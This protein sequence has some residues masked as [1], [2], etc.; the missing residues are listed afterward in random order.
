MDL[1]RRLEK[2][3]PVKTCVAQ[4]IFFLVGED[5]EGRTKSKFSSVLRRS[6]TCFTLLSRRVET[7]QVILLSFIFLSK[8]YR[9]QKFHD[10]RFFNVLLPSFIN[11]ISP[12]IRKRKTGF[13][14]I[15]AKYFIHNQ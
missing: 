6:R 14:L 9:L 13:G 7:I 5:S 3:G 2:F 4:K 11:L 12:Y 1:K 10:K 15:S 8:T